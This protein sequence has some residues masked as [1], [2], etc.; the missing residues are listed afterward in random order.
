MRYTTLILEPADYSPRALARYRSLGPVYFFPALRGKARERAL[1]RAHI[2]VV[3]LAHQIDDRFLDRA[4][5][6]KIIATP[7]TGLNHIDGGAARKREVRVISLRGH[8]KFLARIPSTAE[9]TFA[10]MFALIRRIP[11]AF[12]DVKKGYWNRDAWRG[13]QLLGKTFGILGCGRLGKLVAQYAR[14]FG[15]RVIGFDPQV[16]VASMRRAGIES[17]SRMQLLRQSDIM[18]VHVLLDENTHDLMSARDLRLMRRGAYLINTARGELIEKNALLAALKKKWIAG[19]AIDVMRDES[20]D[21]AHLQR[22]PLRAYAR[23]HDNLLIVPHIGGATYEAMHATE[24]F[25]ADLVSRS[26]LGKK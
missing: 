17:V 11:W 20:A 15:M 3:R 13:H 1:A 4:K 26:V 7:T 23:T 25:V 16:S 22:D 14:A 24:D 12:D 21:G 10:L 2:L 9:E 8:A 6:L 18:S 19:A 5:R